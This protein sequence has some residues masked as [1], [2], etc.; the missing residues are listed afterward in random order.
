MKLAADTLILHQP[1]ESNRGIWP[2]INISEW[3]R[4]R[5]SKRSEIHTGLKKLGKPVDLPVHQIRKE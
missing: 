1:K 2:S 3:G 5:E 4:F